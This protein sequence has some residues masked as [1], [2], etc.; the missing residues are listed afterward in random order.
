MG[1]T[2]ESPRGPEDRRG[3][4]RP[5]LHFSPPSGWL[6][7]PNGL[8]YLDGEYHL[9]YQ[10]NPGSDVWGPMHWGHAVSSDLCDWAHLRVALAPDEHGWIYSGSAVVDREG[11]A[12]LGRGVMVAA[13]TY[14][15]A[16]GQSQAIASSPDRGRTWH[17][18]DENPVLRAPDGEPDFRD[19]KVLRW[20]GDGDGHWV[21]VVAAGPRVLF[22]VS[23]DLR[24]W[25]PSSDLRPAGP[26]LE[27][28][29]ETPDLFPLRVGGGVGGGVEE[30]WVLSL[31]ATAGAPAGGGGPCYVV[32]DFDGRRFM[33]APTAAGPARAGSGAGADPADPGGIHPLRWADRGP[34]FYAAQSWNGHPAG[35]RVW[36]AWMGSW[37]YAEQVPSSGWRGM[38]SLPRRLGLTRSSDGIVLTQSPVEAIRARRVPAFTWS[39]RDPGGAPRPGRTGDG[40]EVVDA[41]EALRG[42]RFDAFDLSLRLRVAGDAP[43]RFDLVV[44]SGEDERTSVSYD[45]PAGLLT[46]DR[47]RSGRN[48]F[49]RDHPSVF[50]ARV[51]P[52]DGLVTLRVVGDTCSVEVFANDGRATITALVFPSRPG[53]TLSVGGSGDALL[54]ESLEVLDLS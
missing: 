17:L 48:A 6:N 8:V 42:F 4:G 28:T 12:G 7:D 40:R 53:F 5:R 14:A 43:A 41:N 22:Y 32:G 27:V 3:P 19:P 20:G 38:M 51:Q 31:G 15:S 13:F 44:A 9:F 18:L 24:T 26:E 2:D 47:T 37:A 23:S 35:E 1:G 46:L 45:S 21:M 34:D 29:W 52:I 10:H 11:T 50:P 16:E 25:E 30:R 36:I 39:P 54:C 49:H 33:P